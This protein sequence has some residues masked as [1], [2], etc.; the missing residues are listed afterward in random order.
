MRY[1][2]Q[3]DKILEPLNHIWQ[4]II[5]RNNYLLP[6][7]NIP[8]RD[9]LKNSVPTI[10]GVIAVES[11]NTTWGKTLGKTTTLVLLESIYTLWLIIVEQMKFSITDLCEGLYFWLG[12]KRPVPCKLNC[13]A[14]DR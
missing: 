9:S 7:L 4:H 3:L 5:E 8:S 11:E 14:G 6:S 10:A 12:R 13:D 1:L 2:V